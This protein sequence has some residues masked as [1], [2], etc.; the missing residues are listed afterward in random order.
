M[1]ANVKCKQQQ[2]SK[3]LKVV[4]GRQRPFSPGVPAEAGC[5]FTVAAGVHV[6]ISG[7]SLHCFLVGWCTNKSYVI[8][9][10]D[11][12]LFIHASNLL[13]LN[14]PSPLPYTCNLNK[15]WNPSFPRVRFHKQ[16]R[17]VCM[18]NGWA[19]EPCS[20]RTNQHVARL[21][22]LLH[23]HFSNSTRI[24]TKKQKIGMY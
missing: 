11:L 2:L 10:S 15:H 7:E 14:S 22:V 19:R 20:K 4:L 17:Q 5:L 13:P 24:P 9:T 18:T 21:P 1:K 12:W 6:F 3:V 8:A 16:E 23:C